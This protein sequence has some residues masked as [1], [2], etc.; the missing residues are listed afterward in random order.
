MASVKKKIVKNTIANTLLS[1]SNYIIAFL[2]FPFIIGYIGVVDYGLYL[3][4]GAFVGYFGL[5]DFGVGG[6]LVKYIAE[7]KEKQKMDSI[8][9]VINSTFAFYLIIG[10]VIC[11]FISVIGFFY[12]DLFG[13]D[14]MDTVRPY[15][16]CE[17][18]LGLWFSKRIIGKSSHTINK[19]LRKA[20]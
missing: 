13:I 9:E 1:F 10:I 7:Y 6:A 4:V 20:A 16:I 19:S 11:I 18:L 15:Y 2:M 8:N 3:L 5:F 17:C 12:V 14:E